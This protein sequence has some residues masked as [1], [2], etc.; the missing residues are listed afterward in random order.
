MPRSFPSTAPKKP[1]DKDRKPEP[2]L[3]SD[4]A[5]TGQRQPAQPHLGSRDL[6]RIPPFAVLHYCTR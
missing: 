6:A 4:E 5:F 1:H 2:G 3:V